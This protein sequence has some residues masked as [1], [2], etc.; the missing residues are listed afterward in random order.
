MWLEPWYSM[1]MLWCTCGLVPERFCTFETEPKKSHS[2]NKYLRTS[3]TASAV[4]KAPGSVNV[5]PWI[6]QPLS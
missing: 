2:Q 5:T 6:A 1:C 3:H 4:I